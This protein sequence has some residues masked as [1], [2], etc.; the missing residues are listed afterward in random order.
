MT[1]LEIKILEHFKNNPGMNTS[2]ATFGA[3]YVDGKAAFDNLF[4][5]GLLVRRKALSP[6]GERMSAQIFAV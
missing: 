2:F 6:T 3:N 1:D 5:A 4:A